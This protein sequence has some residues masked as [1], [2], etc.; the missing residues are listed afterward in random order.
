MTL[1]FVDWFLIAA[2]G[3]GMLVVSW[4]SRRRGKSSA[5]EMILGGRLLSVPGFVA[6]LVSTWYGGILGVGEFTWRYGISNWVIFGVPYYIFA[7][8]FALAFAKR[9]RATEVL[10]I[11]DLLERRFGAAPARFG[12]FL[13]YAISSPAPYFLMQGILIQVVTGWSLL[14]ALL[15]GALLTTVLLASGGFSSL[16]NTDLL[17]FFLMFAGFATLL[18]VLIASQGLAPLG[19]DSLPPHH[20]ELFGGHG[21]QY[22][23][24]W[25]FIASWTIVAPPFHQFTLSAKDGKTAVRGILWS[26]V[27]WM[28]F[29]AMTTL[30]GLYARALLPHL[31]EP[32]M[33]FPL[34]GDAVLPSFFKGLFLLGMMAT[35]MSTTNGFTFI[36]SATLG[37]DVLAPLFT[38][39]DDAGIRVST[40][41]A[42]ALT[43]LLS[44]GAALALPS[45][46]DLWYVIGTVFI[47]G[48]LLPVLTASYPRFALSPRRT[49]VSMLTGF[50]TSAL[51]YGAGALMGTP[52]APL[53]PWG[54]EPMFPG[55]LASLMPYLG[56]RV[57][58][59][60][61]PSRL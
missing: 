29:D 51:W 27:F 7:V 56:T 39:R 44:V 5:A 14:P 28:V 42:T 33:A 34:L 35:I 2:Y 23:L 41:L 20:L 40:L 4:A 52:H 10:S 25:F 48:I 59:D 26:V 18:V 36:A 12:A 6:G 47:P 31:S 60:R 16:V 49:L 32:T 30:C 3:A 11:P 17:Q 22:I 15:V 13:V 55:I 50:G 46:I 38:W 45:I 53:Y 54:I 9:V 61:P 19:P 1:S 24:V 37:H 21:I 43:I 57:F 58:V 8:I